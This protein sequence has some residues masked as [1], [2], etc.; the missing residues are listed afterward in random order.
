MNVFNKI[1][2]KLML[3]RLLDFLDRNDVLSKYQ[4]GFRKDHSTTLV[5][6]EITENIRKSLENG[7]LVAGVYLDLSKAFD[8]VDHEI[9]LYKL[10]LTRLP[11]QITSSRWQSGQGS[12]WLIE[13]P[14]M[15]SSMCSPPLS[16]ICQF[17]F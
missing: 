8:T 15:F 10:D 6:I 4:F 11:S 3:K 13:S 9:L 5:I 14:T 16:N 2:E 17:Y 12:H 1:L 7:D